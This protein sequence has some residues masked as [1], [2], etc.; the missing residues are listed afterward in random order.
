MIS[1]VEPVFGHAQS[2]VGIVSVQWEY[3]M[4]F[5]LWRAGKDKTPVSKTVFAPM[6]AAPSAASPQP[7]PGDL[8]LRVIWQALLRRKRS[9]IIPTLLAFVLSLIVVNLITPRY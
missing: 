5:A 2:T 3:A 8:D 1:K 7:Q 9:I 6:A 4:R